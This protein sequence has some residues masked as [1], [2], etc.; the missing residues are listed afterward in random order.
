M[1]NES[2]APDTLNSCALSESATAG[3]EVKTESGLEPGPQFFNYHEFTEGFYG[4]VGSPDILREH[5]GD[6]NICITH[7]PNIYVPED[8]DEF[9]ST[10]I[11]RIPRRFDFTLNT[12]C[13]S[14]CLPGW[15]PAALNIEPEQGT[16]IPHGVYD[17]GQVFG[18]S[19]VSPLSK[20]LSQSEFEKI[21]DAVNEILGRAYAIYTWRNLLDLA[22]TVLTLGTWHLLSRHLFKEPTQQLE[23]YVSQVNNS[24]MFRQQNIKIISPGRS[25]YLSVCVQ[26][27]A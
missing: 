10:R 3:Q 17:N 26:M 23:D 4:D 5:D 6:H 14:N 7:F 8:S 2:A 9:R 18:Y 16:F 25:G 1:E 13:F 15:E 20:Y 22:L 24:P 11:V 21:S 12:P 27:M 19:S